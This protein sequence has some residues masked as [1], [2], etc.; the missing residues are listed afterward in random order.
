MKYELAK[1]L[2]EAGFLQEGNG[3]YNTMAEMSS[4][5]IKQIVCDDDTEGAVYL[6][7][8]PELIEACGE[9][10]DSLWFPPEGIDGKKI[11]CAKPKWDWRKFIN[12]DR[13]EGKTPE[14]AV[15]KLYIAL[16]KKGNDLR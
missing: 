9:S 13:V 2:K 14:E 11:W 16:N 8:L 1:Q 10:F 15:A 7:N 5:G 12:G 4:V 6:P 3:E